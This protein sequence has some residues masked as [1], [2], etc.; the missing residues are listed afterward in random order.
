MERGRGVEPSFTEARGND[1][2]VGKFPKEGGTGT[3]IEETS[4]EWHV[5]E[6]WGWVRAGIWDQALDWAQA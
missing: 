5:A 6:K 1:G 2:G 4:G 3:R